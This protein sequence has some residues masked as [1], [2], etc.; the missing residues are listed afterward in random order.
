VKRF[1]SHAVAQRVGFILEYVQEKRKVRVEPEIIEDLLRLT[2]SKIYP[3]D[4]KSSK[5]GET[6]RK[7]KIINNAG[8][9]EI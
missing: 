2:G 1:G 5:S 9:V 6:L 4:V 8:Y 3:L 7:W